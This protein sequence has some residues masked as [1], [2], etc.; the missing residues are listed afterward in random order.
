MMLLLEVYKRMDS[1][2]KVGLILGIIITMV[3]VVVVSFL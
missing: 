3:I 1:E 2:V